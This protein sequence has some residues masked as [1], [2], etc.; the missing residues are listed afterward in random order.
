MALKEHTYEP[1]AAAGY[2]GPSSAGRDLFIVLIVTL[3]AFVFAAK[4]ELSEWIL[5]KTR[6]VEP[7]QLDELPL[8]IVVLVLSMAWFSWRRWGQFAKEYTLRLEA[9]QALSDLL[10]ENRLLARKN[11]LAQEEERRV[12]ARE[13]H[14]ELGQS[15]NAIKLDAVAIREGVHDTSNEIHANATAIIEVADHVQETVRGLTRRLRPVALDELGLRDALELYVNQWERRNP[16]TTCTLEASGTLEDLG[17]LVNI[18]LYRCVQECLTNV[19]RHARAT[20]VKVLLAQDQ[21]SVRLVVEDNGS[22]MDVHAKRHGLGLVGL[23]ERAESLNGSLEVSS[24][25]GAGTRITLS[26]SLGSIPKMTNS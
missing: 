21:G 26:L 25:P 13:L 14:D 7:Y 16:P 12:L 18:T 22:G 4:V 11:V 15:L 19:T 3:A 23:R 24:A 6:P 9:Q 5:S 17:E 1:P 2:P 10:A 20:A 8:T